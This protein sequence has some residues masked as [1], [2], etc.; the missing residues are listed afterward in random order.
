MSKELID[1]YFPGKAL[2]ELTDKKVMNAKKVDTTKVVCAA[3]GVGLAMCLF[4]KIM[5]SRERDTA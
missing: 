2:N 1:Q 5:A 3:I 4:H